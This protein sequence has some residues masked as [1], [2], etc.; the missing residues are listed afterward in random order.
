MSFSCLVV[1]NKTWFGGMQKNL[2]LH[3]EKYFSS[4]VR[5][6][7]GKV[8]RKSGLKLRW[9]WY[10]QVVTNTFCGRLHTNERPDFLIA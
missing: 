3:R 10:L 5:F 8:G 7:H 9:R 2:K 6:L 4:N 1:L